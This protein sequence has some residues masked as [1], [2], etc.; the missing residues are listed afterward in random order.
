MSFQDFLAHAKDK[1]KCPKCEK[2]FETLESLVDPD[3]GALLVKM[4]CHGETHIEALPKE[5]LEE[6]EIRRKLALEA[7]DKKKEE[8]ENSCDLQLVKSLRKPKRRIVTIDPSY[9]QFNKF[10]KLK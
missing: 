6:L 4:E 8:I 1:F 9:Y 5:E 10:R 3:N 7:I 2:P